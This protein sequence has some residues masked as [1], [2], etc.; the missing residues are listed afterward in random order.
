[1]RN[2]QLDIRHLNFS[3]RII[4]GRKNKKYQFFITFNK[5][6]SNMISVKVSYTVRDHFI[7]QNTKNIH[8]FLKDFESLNNDDFSYSIFVLENKKTFVHLSQYK[9]STIQQEL[10][11]IPSFLSFQNQRDENLETQPVIEVLDLIGT[12]KPL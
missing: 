10:L 6:S 3:C 7:D 8:L 9:N 5:K 1:M 4:E 12:S 2:Q 11:T